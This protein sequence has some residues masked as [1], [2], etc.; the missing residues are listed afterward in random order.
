MKPLELSR[1]EMKEIIAG[2]NTQID[3]GICADWAVHCVCLDGTDL[4]CQT[5]GDCATL[6]SF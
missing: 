6:C 5:E 4:G 1:N 2:S 3:G